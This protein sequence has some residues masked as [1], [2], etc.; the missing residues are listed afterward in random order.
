MPLARTS[1]LLAS[2][3]LRPCVVSS[4]N[5]GCWMKRLPQKVLISYA[6]MHDY[7][8]MFIGSYIQKR[9]W[10]SAP[11]LPGGNVYRPTCSPRF[12]IHR[13]LEPK[14][15][16]KGWWMAGLSSVPSK[17]T[18]C[19]VEIMHPPTLPNVYSSNVYSSSASESSM[20][21]LQQNRFSH[22]F[23]EWNQFECQLQNYVLFELLLT[24]NDT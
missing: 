15:W 6:R 4:F 16:P 5:S 24:I 22:Q 17:M 19:R 11:V 21:L 3:H 20:L 8:Y 9:L 2:A 12:A 10:T 7:A 18:S 13:T 1:T 23:I 14:S